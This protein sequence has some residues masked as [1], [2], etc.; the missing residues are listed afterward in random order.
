M[1]TLQEIVQHH[2]VTTYAEL[3]RF[4]GVSE[5]YGNLL[6]TG[7]RKPSLTVI[8]TLYEKTGVA[9]EILMALRTSDGKKRK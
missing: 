5:S 6:W 7:R 1:K 2:D 8:Q 3:A 4:L 9:Y